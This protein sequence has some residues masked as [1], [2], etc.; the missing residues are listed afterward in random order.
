MV[1][2]NR[3]TDGAATVLLLE[4]EVRDGCSGYANGLTK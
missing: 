4:R 2:A 1:L 3:L